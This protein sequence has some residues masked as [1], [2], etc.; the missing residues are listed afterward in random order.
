[1]FIRPATNDDLPQLLACVQASVQATYGGL[2][3]T[4]PLSVWDDDWANAWIAAVDDK[5]IGVGLTCADV[6]SDLWAHPS[7]QARGAGTQLLSALEAEI[8]ARG[9]TTARLRCLEPNTKA[10][11]FYAARG[12]SEVRTY[13]HETIPFNTVDM[14]KAGGR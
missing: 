9:F 5:I 2:W 12:W 1:M 3:S 10:R 8:F 14:L 7:A 6:L 4:E 11:A 13:R